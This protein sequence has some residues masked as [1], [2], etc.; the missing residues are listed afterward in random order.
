MRHEVPLHDTS[1]EL[2]GQRLG[3]PPASKYHHSTPEEMRINRKSQA[4]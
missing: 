3:K 4:C 1:H 2:T